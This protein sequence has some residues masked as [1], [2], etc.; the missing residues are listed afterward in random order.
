MHIANI[1][2][3]PIKFKEMHNSLEAIAVD[4]ASSIYLDRM[5]AFRQREAASKH[6]RYEEVQYSEYEI[7]PTLPAIYLEISSIEGS[8]TT[9][10]KVIAGSLAFLIGAAWYG[11]TDFPNFKS[12]ISEMCDSNNLFGSCV[13]RD[14]MEKNLISDGHL[15]R[16]RHEQMDIRRILRLEKLISKLDRQG[17]IL[18]VDAVSLLT[19][20]ILNELRLLR[21]RLTLNSDFILT[22]RSL[23]NEKESG[24]ILALKSF[25]ERDPDLSMALEQEILPKAF[26]AIDGYADH[27]ITSNKEVSGYACRV[28]ESSKKSGLLEINSLITMH[29]LY[30]EGD[31]RK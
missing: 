14:Y 6:K 2:F 7:S 5:E 23:L 18:S 30:N 4:H 19:N 25:I 13:L 16:K 26:K 3:D 11:V 27:Q 9:N 21:N 28:K 10:V 29:L 17:E 22:V 12:G 31:G 1:Q 24:S 8:L 20:E 15:T